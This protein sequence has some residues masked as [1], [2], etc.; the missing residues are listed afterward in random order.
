MA[1]GNGQPIEP[2]FSTLVGEIRGWHEEA[3]KTGG[4]PGERTALLYASVGRAFQSAF[5]QPIYPTDLEK[6]AALFH[7]IVCNHPFVDG[8]KRTAIFT[9]ILFLIAREVLAPPTPVQ[10]RMLGQLAIELAAAKPTLSVQDVIH[11]FH[12]ILDP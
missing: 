6:G 10:I 5:G 3:L 4:A 1:K 7:S 9:G 2:W 12:R 8:N 11:W